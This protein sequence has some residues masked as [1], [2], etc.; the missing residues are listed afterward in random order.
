[1]S[2]T[3]T[4]AFMGCVAIVAMM[5]IHPEAAQGSLAAGS[6][7]VPGG[8]VL[9]EESFAST[10]SGSVPKG[11]IVKGQGDV[12]AVPGV[13][14][15]WLKLGPEANLAPERLKLLPKEVTI[16]L[17]LLCSTPFMKGNSLSIALGA[18]KK[19]NAFYR[20]YSA[21][22]GDVVLTLRVHPGDA[23][24]ESMRGYG[25]YTLDM[26]GEGN[27]KSAKGSFEIPSFRANEHQRQARISVWRQDR[28][29]RVYV[30]DDMVLDQPGLLPEGT[31]L[32]AMKLGAPSYRGDNQYYVGNI[33]IA[34]GTQAGTAAAKSAEPEA[35]SVTSEQAR[36]GPTAS[37]CEERLWSAKVP[38][39]DSLLRPDAYTTHPLTRKYHKQIT[40]ILRELE[41][42]VKAAVVPMG[43]LG[44]ST[45]ILNHD[46]YA[47]DRPRHDA[48]YQYRA[49]FLQ[50][51]CSFRN[52]EEGDIVLVDETGTWF[53]ID[54]N[55]AANIPGFER[56][57]FFLSGQDAQG[58]YTLMPPRVF[59]RGVDPAQ[60]DHE[61][62]LHGRLSHYK[63]FHQVFG[64]AGFYSPA[65]SVVF[66]TP[67]DGLPYDPVGIGEFLDINE[68]RLNAYVE[69]ELRYQTDPGNRE[70]FLKK[71]NGY[72][73]RIQV[74][75]RAYAD[76]LK[77]PA[78]IKVSDWDEHQLLDVDPFEPAGHGF[79]V[80]RRS[81]RYFSNKDNYR[82]KFFTV[83]WQWEP[84]GRFSRHV[85]E[86]VLLNL[87]LEALKNMLSK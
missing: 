58:L 9:I 20:N 24:Y 75:R 31:Q 67:D 42:R 47:K 11:W 62:A 72:L 7:F 36:G 21:D 78:Y 41:Q 87:D 84:A 66:I 60:Q 23:K 29:V 53:H 18:V 48:T 68:R 54:V 57:Q 73:Q 16:E 12:V 17:D 4:P 35:G 10:I 51:Q 61:I 43:S 80:V 13:P 37:S 38:W 19:P 55:S 25:E 49:H 52:R 27:T 39:K 64:G 65:L 33:R 77:Q 3:I 30:N 22:S 34:E 26:I 50:Y 82:P 70:R 86:S 8:K 45:L 40:P 32:N 6:D 2:R 46:P 71:N 81:A 79:L 44:K 56:G 85:H 28:R 69:R 83:W 63:T 59:G 15:N 1:M 74:L 76:R 14:G 5:C